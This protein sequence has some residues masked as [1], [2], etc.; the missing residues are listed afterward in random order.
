MSHSV[1]LS[2]FYNRILRYTDSSL[3]AL[4]LAC[5]LLQRKGGRNFFIW[6]GRMAGLLCGVGL[7]K[8]SAE[9]RLTAG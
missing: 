6:P 5:T 9:M 2:A 8:K 1:I 3:T 7:L 4:G